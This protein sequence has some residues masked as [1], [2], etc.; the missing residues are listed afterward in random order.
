MWAHFNRFGQF[1]SQLSQ[2]SYKYSTFGQIANMEHIIGR[3]KELQEF[4]R[5]MDTGASEFIAVYGRR[6]VGKTFLIRE[7]FQ[8]KFDF[9]MTGMAN[10][11]LSQQLT[12][13]H[14]AI[15]KYDTGTITHTAANWLEAF[16][17]LSLLLEK[18]KN[19]KKIIFLDEMPWLDTPQSGFIQ[20][21]EFFWNSWA[22]ARKDVLLIVCGSAASWMLNKL[23]HNKGGLY[24]RVT[25][26]MKL[27]PF[28]LNECEQYFKSRSGVYDR[29][30]LI[31]LYMVMGGIPFY[32]K[33][34][35]TGRSATQNI[36]HLCF[37]PGGV[38][39][40]EFDTLYR[41]LFNNADKHI[42]IIETLSKKAKGLTREEL[43][44]HTGMPSGGN[45]TN[46]LKELEESGFIRKYSSY[47]KKEKNS[48]YQ[49][50]DFYSLFYLKFIK[51]KDQL[52]ENHWL[53][54]LDNPKQRSWAGYAFEQVCLAHSKAI[55]AALGI[56]GVQT[57]FS[58]W[59]GTRKEKGAQV[60]LVI[61]RRDGVIN[62]CETKFSISPFTIN[63]KYADELRKKVAAFRE[64]T[65]TRKATFLTLVTTFGL[66]RNMHAISLV[67][68]DITM[69]ALFG[70]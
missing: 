31:Q 38:L 5:L 28:T 16:H 11:P 50:T 53:N 34:V 23:I 69:D 30:Q 55:K 62:L 19:K 20:A 2:M 12:N 66:N 8:N 54:G 48:L 26:R 25:H 68:N 65:R 6:R 70:E 39:F 67:Q 10:V 21:L 17:Q 14:F 44:A 59:T 13:F 47:G 24:N 32:L 60:D 27:E 7:A 49:L 56:S 1:A 29:Y 36:S 41:S 43:I 22:S 61:D 63:K 52:D 4:R 37:D 64:Q 45:T 51:G 40:D 3:V 15:K 58:S 18:V 35:D 33:Q 57:A 46:I 42:A 9:Y